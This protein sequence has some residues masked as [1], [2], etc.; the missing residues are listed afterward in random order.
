VIG[1]QHRVELSSHGPHEHRIC[2]Q[3]TRGLKHLRRGPKDPLLLVAEQ[4]RLAGMRIHRADRHSG[5]L[6]APPVPQRLIHGLPGSHHPLDG[7][8]GWHVPERHMGRDQYHA[9]RMAV[10]IAG[11][12][13]GGQHHRHI[14]IAGEVGQPFGVTGIGEAGEMEGMLVGGG[15]DDGVHFA[16]ESE[17]H[18]RFDRV[19]GDAARADLALAVRAGVAAAVSPG[20]DRYLTLRRNAGDLV[21]RANQGDLSFERLG[22]GA[23]RDL[24]P[25]PTRIPQRDGEPRT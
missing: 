3:R 16:A 10:G 9:Q 6:D 7:E 24:G 4:A 20:S 1:G 11:C 18:G 23:G 13:F 8:Q 14:D 21:L 25:D 2:R 5:P 22:Q 17:L 12:G 19:A 15:G